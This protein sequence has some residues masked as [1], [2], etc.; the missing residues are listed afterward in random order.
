MVSTA[1][2][3]QTITTLSKHERIRDKIDTESKHLEQ[4]LLR[5]KGKRQQD[6]FVILEIDTTLKQLRGNLDQ[7]N[8]LVVHRLRLQLARKKLIR[9]FNNAY[10]KIQQLL[11]TAVAEMDYKIE[12]SRVMGSISSVGDRKNTSQES[13][14]RELLSSRSSL[15]TAENNISEVR[16]VALETQMIEVSDQLSVLSIRGELAL[17]EFVSLSENFDPELA[18]ALKA[19]V[20]T[21]RNAI[22][23]KSSLFTGLAAESLATDQIRSVLD[24]N[25][26]VSLDMSGAVDQLVGR[27]KKNISDAI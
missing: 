20:K 22:E 9:E 11:S 4:I 12:M 27:G 14:E 23:G 19:P 17:G 3:M 13:K 25:Q 18:S 10:V 6:D 24:D 5:L 1:S 7:L 15:K 26:W 2:E 16:M 8:D 21:F